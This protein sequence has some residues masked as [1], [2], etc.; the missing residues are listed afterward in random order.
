LGNSKSK[1]GCKG[2]Y[3]AKGPQSQGLGL[4]RRRK[5]VVERTLVIS[6]PLKGDQRTKYSFSN[7]G[8]QQYTC[9]EYGMVSVAKI[10]GRKVL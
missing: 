5:K 10:L 3:K 7:G 2:D 4:A 6:N 8:Y 9:Q 1:E